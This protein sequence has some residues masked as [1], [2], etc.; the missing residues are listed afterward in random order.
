MKSYNMTY[1]YSVGIYNP[2]RNTDM[3]YGSAGTGIIFA[4]IGTGRDGLEQ[5][6]TR[7]IKMKTEPA[8]MSDS[9]LES[10]D[11]FR[12]RQPGFRAAAT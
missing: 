7:Q 12:A 1:D 11:N 8:R 5:T 6:M 9:G 4:D 3:S 10:T 2:S